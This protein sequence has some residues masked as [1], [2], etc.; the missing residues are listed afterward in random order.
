MNILESVLVLATSEKG[1][2]LPMEVDEDGKSLVQHDDRTQIYNTTELCYDYY[3]EEVD[4]FF[5]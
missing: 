1:Y 3:K 4:G 2:I 5:S